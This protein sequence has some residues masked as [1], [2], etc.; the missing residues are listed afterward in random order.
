MTGGRASLAALAALVALVALAGCDLGLG[1]PPGEVPCILGHV[2]TPGGCRVVESGIDIDGRAADWAALVET[3]V[4]ATCL[5]PP[6]EGTLPVAVQMAVE[7][8]PV[9]C[10]PSIY[11]HVR[12]AG[13]P[14]MDPE[15]R[16]V[17]QLAPTPERPA[18]EI[19]ALIAGA[20]SSRFEK[21]GHDVTP[22][23]SSPTYH[24][25]AWTADGYEAGI[26]AS[27]VPLRGA[28]LVSLYAV[29]GAARQ[30]VTDPTPVTRVCWATYADEAAVLVPTTADPCDI[31]AAA[32]R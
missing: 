12:I 25:F 1:S 9:A 8:C 11:F 4:S 27:Y 20:A 3:P 31:V 16:M 17:L 29:R 21:N 24:Q 2:R 22:T 10:A 28:A 13:G 32:P 19:D 26:P 5:S 18:A 14:S 6:C 7:P 30:P 23:T 15:L